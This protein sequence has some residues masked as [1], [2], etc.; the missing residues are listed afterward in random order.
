MSLFTSRGLPLSD[1]QRERDAC[2]VGFV[3]NIKG[4]R[5]HDLVTKGLLALEHLE[6]RGAC[7]CDPESGDGAGAIVHVPHEFFAE[8]CGDAGIKLPEP[9]AYGVGMVFLPP[10]AD[11]LKQ[12]RKLLEEAVARSGLEVLGW[13]DV[14]IDERFCGKV[15]MST[16]PHIAQIFIGCGKEKLDE[17]ALERRLYVVRRISENE[18]QATHGEIAEHFYLS[19]LS[20]RTICYKGMLMSTQVLGFFPDLQDARFKSAICLVHSRFSTNT[21]PTW[22]LAQPFRYLA[23]NGEINTVRGNQNWMSAREKLFESELFGDRMHELIPIV[24][25]GQSDSAVFDNGLEL[26]Y[27]TGRA[28]PHA[29]MM[30]IPEAW[31]KHESMEE[32]RKAFYRYHGCLRSRGTAPHRSRSPTAAASA[33][34]STATACARRATPSPTT[35]SSSWRRKPACSRCP[36]ATSS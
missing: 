9:G 5:T 17:D 24:E 16:K 20:C 2:G 23:H 34:C 3:A 14:P 15:S 26:L 19:S 31:E 4:E 8:V 25:P 7:G 27:Q 11:A 22:R 6:H 35:A 29:V 30:M 18:S 13:R 28:L 33:R 32:D 12:A 10:S 1:Y 21:L 36:R